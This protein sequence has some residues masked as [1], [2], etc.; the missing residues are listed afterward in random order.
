MKVKSLFIV[1]TFF[2]S[3]LFSQSNKYLLGTWKFESSKV[4]KDSA[5]LIFKEGGIYTCIGKI[6][7]DAKYEFDKTSNE[8]LLWFKDESS[9][10]LG[11]TWFKFNKINQQEFTL[12]AYQMKIFENGKWETGPFKTYALVYKKQK[13]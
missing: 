6:N 5:A 10:S 3:A 7:Y 1:L 11:I 13:K 8:L 12:T 9:D 2:S 4:P